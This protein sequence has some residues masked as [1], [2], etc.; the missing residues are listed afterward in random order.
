MNKSLI[1]LFFFL[2]HFT[3]KAQTV[4]IPASTC[5]YYGEAGEP[6]KASFDFRSDNEAEKIINA[7][8]DVVGLKPNFIIQSAKVPNAAAVILKGK[9][10]V[11]YNQN[12]ISQMDKVSNSRW[13]SI[14]ILAHEVGHHLNGHTLTNTG[15]RPDIELE[16]DEFSGFVLRKMGAPLADAQLA[17]KIAASQKASHTHPAKASRLTAIAKGWKNADSQMTGTRS[18]EIE[19]IKKPVE[20]IPARPEISSVLD[21]KYIKYE[22]N[23]NFHPDGEYYVTI[24]NNLVRVV[25]EKIEILGR[26]AASKTKKYPFVLYQSDKNY[27]FVNKN[28]V[29]VTTKG[30]NAGY[31]KTPD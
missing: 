1:F 7:I 20:K 11:L 26:F 31:M 28:G 21:P 13:A 30:E 16:A 19:K 12:F 25:N 5:F 29:I 9:R 22:V 6:T 17:M 14:S 23:F 8:I 24:K 10:Y 15:S 18:A 3:I 4:I 27:L 2:I